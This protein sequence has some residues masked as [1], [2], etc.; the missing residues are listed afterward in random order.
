MID[1]QL[2][3]KHSKYAFQLINRLTIVHPTRRDG[4]I[5]SCYLKSTDHEEQ[6]VVGQNEVLRSCLLQL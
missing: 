1:N 2:R 6:I 5:M 4:G 3:T